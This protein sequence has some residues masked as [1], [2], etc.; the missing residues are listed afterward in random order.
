MNFKIVADSAANRYTLNDIPFSYAPLKIIAD[1]EYVDDEHL[2]VYQMAQNIKNYNG[3]STTSCPNS[4]E[5]EAAFADAQ[6]I[7]GVAITSQLSGSYNA[8]VL[9][10]NEY[11][12]KYPERK[13]HI[14]DS[15]ST[16]PEMKMIVDKLHDLILEGLSFEEIKEQ[17]TEYM[18]HTYLLFSLESV[19]NLAK[20]GRVNP[21]VALAVNALG[22][23][24]IGDAEGGKLN[25]RNKCRGEKKGLATLY[26]NMKE[27]GFTGKKVYIGHNFN[28][29]GANRLKEMIL[30]DYPECVIDMQTNHGLNCFY[31]ELGGILVGFEGK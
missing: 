15:L 11:M 29:T 6:Y 13:V 21:A 5:W 19:A 2:D 1:Q 27:K 7:F 4:A 25:Q 17:I 3:R 10:A 22:I 20:N 14:I 12:E 31:A 30:A 26:S 28:E 18:K 9:A 24:I 16:G 8:G 23:R